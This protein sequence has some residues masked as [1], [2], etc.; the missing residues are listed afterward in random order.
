MIFILFADIL[1]N[2]NF[3]EEFD[4]KCE[5]ED[6][7]YLL[8]N[9]IQFKNRFKNL[10]IPTLDDEDDIVG[11][12]AKI[13]NYWKKDDVVLVNMVIDSDSYIIFPIELNNAKQLEKLN[14]NFI[15]FDTY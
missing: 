12:S 3:A 4:W 8:S 7:E 9:L 5:L 6:F 14:K 13:T 15:I 2:N 11:W 10:T 1:I